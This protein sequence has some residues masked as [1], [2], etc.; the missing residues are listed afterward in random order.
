MR[1]SEKSRGEEKDE[2]KRFYKDSVIQYEKTI[3]LFQQ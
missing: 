3:Q 2:E 1:V